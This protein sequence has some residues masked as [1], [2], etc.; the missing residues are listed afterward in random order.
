MLLVTGTTL[1]VGQFILLPE[2]L[3]KLSWSAIATS[4]SA[5]N[6]Y[7]TYFLDTSYFAPDASQ[8]PLLHMW[9]LG[10]EEQF[11]LVWPAFLASTVLI[12]HR[13]LM[14]C[15]IL[16]L[17]AGSFILAETLTASSPMFAYYMLPTRAGQLLIGALCLLV[18]ER[19]NPNSF[20]RCLILQTIGLLLIITSLFSLDHESAF[21]GINAISVTLGA[22][23]LIIG[24]NNPSFRT[25]ITAYL[26]LR[27]MVGIGLI[28][29]SLYLWHWP[30]LAFAKYSFGEIALWTKLASLVVMFGLS[31][32][33]Y[34]LVELPC[35]N[36]KADFSPIFFKQLLFPTFIVCLVAG[37]LIVFK[38]FGISSLNPDYQVSLNEIPQRAGDK[39]FVC[40]RT[41]V[42][43]GFMR[44][45]DCVIGAHYSDDP[46]TPFHQ[47]DPKILLWGDSNAAHYVGF[48]GELAHSYG[49]SFRNIAHGLCLPLTESP[50]RFAPASRAEDCAASNKTVVSRLGLYDTIILGGAWK[51]PIEKFEDFLPALENTI[52][53]LIADGKQVILLGRVPFIEDIDE[54]CSSKALK[55]KFLDCKDRSIV[56]LKSVEAYN[57]QLREVAE[58]AGASYYDISKF[59]CDD[60]VCSGYLEDTLLYRDPGHIGMTASIYLGTLA[61]KDS[62][63]FKVFGPLKDNFNGGKPQPPP[64]QLTRTTK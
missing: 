57:S 23:A 19:F 31:F 50:E 28:S 44:E 34:K 56:S 59:L 9:S 60:D 26:S 58:R 64:W 14:A 35:R 12:I 7:F 21:P 39:E 54:K 49:F 52:R 38:G 8:Q 36:T 13:N 4:V 33:S 3:V 51:R 27:L 10:V 32:L 55:L 11:Y 41:R 18:L 53:S 5:A 43:P 15:I 62:E 17:I 40:Q 1:V 45:A 37:S 48:L 2:D 25:P 61:S 47:R 16:V 46:D 20:A 6:I 22:A 42:T 24:G 30:V 63:A 29:Y